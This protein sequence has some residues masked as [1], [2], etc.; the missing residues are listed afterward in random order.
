MLSGL[1]G[2]G[3]TGSA[4][5]VDTYEG[6]IELLLADYPDLSGV[7]GFLLLEAGE[8]GVYLAVI[9]VEEEGAKPFAILDGT[10][11][12]SGCLLDTYDSATERLQCPCHGSE[13]DL[14]GQVTGGPASAPLPTYP[15]EF[16]GDVLRIDLSDV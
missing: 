3:G 13:F 12:H 11:T 9:R 5:Q 16:D 7:G 14:D 15:H 6:W 1:T 8:T 10:C 2:C 4:E